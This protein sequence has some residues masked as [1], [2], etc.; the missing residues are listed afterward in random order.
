MVAP[1]PVAPALLTPAKRADCDL[2]Q[3][4]DYRLATV[5]AARLCERASGDV[6][7][8][9]HAALASAVRVREKAAADAAKPAR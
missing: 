7:R 1:P 9:K 6:A 3:A 8:A 4:A 2:P 5:N